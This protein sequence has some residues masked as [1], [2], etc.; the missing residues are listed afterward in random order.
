MEKPFHQNIQAV[1]KECCILHYLKLDRRFE[2]KSGKQILKVFVGKSGAHL[3]WY[4][5]PSDSDL[6]G[7]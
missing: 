4:S 2:A 6:P 5:V 1:L 3:C 7:F